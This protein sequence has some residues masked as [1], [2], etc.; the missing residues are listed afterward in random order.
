MQIFR[1]AWRG[2]AEIALR[3]LNVIPRCHPILVDWD[4]ERPTDLSAMLMRASLLASNI[5]HQLRSMLDN[6]LVCMP[7]P[8]VSSGRLSAPQQTHSFV[9]VPFGVN[10]C[11]HAPASLERTNPPASHSD[12]PDRYQP[13][14][15]WRIL[16]D[17]A[18]ETTRRR[19]PTAWTIAQHKLCI[20]SIR[21][22]C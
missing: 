8:H 22:Q 9:V 21:M 20:F 6:K 7:F 15:L 4:G 11:H 10:E 16:A 14:N 17:P 12:F 5:V 3:E 1:A 2:S 18:T 19:S 13:A